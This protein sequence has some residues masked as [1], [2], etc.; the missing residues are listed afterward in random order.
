M[1]G[2]VAIVCASVLLGLAMWFRETRDERA[3]LARVAKLEA[4]AD[5]AARCLEELTGRID[6][7]G[8]TIKH[9]DS[10]IQGVQARVGR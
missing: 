9:H 3:S 1:I 4:R 8:E 6:V 2:E 5:Y 10:R 7:M